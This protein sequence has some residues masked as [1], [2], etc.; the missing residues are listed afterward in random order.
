MKDSHAMSLLPSWALAHL[1]DVAEINPKLDKSNFDDTL[2]VSFVPMPAVEAVTGG[3]DV[4]TTRR[5]G[6]VK[7]GYTAFREG[8]VLF[9]KITPCMENGK[10]AVVPKVCNSLAFGSTEF[11]VLRP[12]CGI[13]ARYIYHFISSQRFR[14]DAEHNMTGAVGQRRVPTAYLAKHLVPIPPSAAQIRIVAKI[15]GLFSELDNGLDSLRTSRQQL[16][17]YREG[18]LKSAFEGKA[19]ARW[20]EQNRG[21]IESAH[22]LIARIKTMRDAHYEA[23]ISTWN[24]THDKNGAK[25]RPPKIFAPLGAQEFAQL[26]TLPDGW[27]WEKLG[28]MTSGV[29]YGTATKSSPSGLVPVLRM[30]NIQSTKFDWSDLVY[31]SDEEEIRQYSLR[32]G[33]V[34]FNRTNS[35][36]LVGK[37]A[38]YR[39]ERPA[40]FAGYLIRVNQIPTIVDSEYLNLFLNS[41]IARQHG[42]RVKTDG[43][44]QSNIN[45][46]KLSNYPFPYCSLAEQREVVKLLA[47]KLSLVDQLESE[48][49]LEIKK[50]EALRQSILIKAFAGKL[51]VENP[52][53]EPASVLLERINRKKVD[54]AN[55]KAKI[56]RK[57]AA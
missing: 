30:G 45:G 21:R 51:V 15:E 29:E 14:Y 38:I 33:D 7:K 11:H 43:V 8:D 42:N 20:R 31:T 23:R 49:D 9:A 48:I 52:H 2:E 39:G 22:R 4:A 18:L 17:V 40:L 50:V 6:E 47:K 13:N 1:C 44:N 19:T 16:K 24:A 10:M 28:W 3:I 26:P 55:A 12:H 53:D 36:E 25:P 32:E 34:L 27:I 46:E 37:T 56:N 57:V 5:F 54:K 35:P 41:H